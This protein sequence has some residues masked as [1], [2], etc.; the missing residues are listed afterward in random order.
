MLVGKRL[1]G[2]CR[3]RRTPFARIS[4]DSLPGELST[5]QVPSGTLAGDRPPPQVVPSGRPAG[6]AG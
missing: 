4:V 2:R 1:W 6:R 3:D 5:D